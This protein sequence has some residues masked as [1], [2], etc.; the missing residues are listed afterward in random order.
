MYYPNVSTEME[1]IDQAL[2][3]KSLS[4]GPASQNVINCCYEI[5]SKMQNGEN[6]KDD[7]DRLE[8]L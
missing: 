4:F 2:E 3:F 6:T 1:K 8:L 5:G 7:L